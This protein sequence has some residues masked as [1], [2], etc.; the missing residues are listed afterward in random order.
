MS[1]TPIL[2][3]DLG[4]YADRQLAPERAALVEAA[5]ARDPAL[6]ER[7]PRSARRARRCAMRSTRC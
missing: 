6:A 5:L 2:D 7:V 3:T 1:T 4:A